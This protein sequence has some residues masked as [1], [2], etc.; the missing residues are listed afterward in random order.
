MK[1]STG[2]IPILVETAKQVDDLPILPN[3]IDE[4]NEGR[5]N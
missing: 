3:G 4:M 1:P 5:K 2:C